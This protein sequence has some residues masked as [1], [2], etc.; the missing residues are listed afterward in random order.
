MRKRGFTLIELL[1]V[2]AIIGILAGI[3]M[4]SL[5]AARAKSRDS[6]RISDLHNIQLALSEYYN[7]NNKYPSTVSGGTRLFYGNCTI[8]QSW[9]TGGLPNSGNGAWIPGNSSQNL[10]PLAPNYLA[11]LPND[12]MSSTDHCYLYS[13]DGVNYMLMAYQTVETYTYGTS[14]NNPYPRQSNT[15]ENDFAL[16]SL[17]S[18]AIGW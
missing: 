7:D 11:T 10:P 2:I 18:G 12:P 6:Q 16:Y 3:I 15:S 1:T 5:G 9:G 17:G 4:T 13:S 8:D 14:G